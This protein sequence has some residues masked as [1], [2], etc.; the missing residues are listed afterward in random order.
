MQTTTNVD[1]PDKNEENKKPYH[2]PE[3][4]VYGNIRE[5]TRNVGSKGNLD[6]GGGAAAGP[7][8]G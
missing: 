3:L 4:V 1:S 5:I 8:T 6:G 7:K 2:K